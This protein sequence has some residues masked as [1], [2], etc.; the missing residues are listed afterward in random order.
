MKDVLSRWSLIVAIIAGWIVGGVSAQDIVFPAPVVRVDGV[1]DVANEAQRQIDA[2]VEVQSKILR[3]GLA[4]RIDE[5][6]RVCDLQPEQLKKF[7][8]AAKGVVERSMETWKKQFEQ[9]PQAFPQANAFFAAP[10]FAQE[11]PIADVEEAPAGAYRP[12]DADG[13]VEAVEDPSVEDQPVDEQPEECDGAEVQPA[14][15]DVA[16]PIAGPPIAAPPFAAPA[17]IPPP[18]IAMPAIQ[19]VPAQVI[20]AMPA[21]NWQFSGA[22]VPD[23]GDAEHHEIWVRALENI[24]TQEQQRL[25]QEARQRRFRFRQQVAIHAIV[26]ELDAALLFTQQQREEVLAMLEKRSDELLAAGGGVMHTTS[27]LH[28]LPDDV[29]QGI[30]SD[31]QLDCIKDFKER[32]NVIFDIPVEQPMQVIPALPAVQFE[33]VIDEEDADDDD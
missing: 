5:L 11:V 29:F 23:A 32:N 16:P 31:A 12:V 15:P 7:Q 14:V 2:I 9:V 6:E 25:Y 33:A 26:A 10:R 24:L 13:Y 20:R 28:Q 22:V 19:M 1:I 3:Q 27:L 8:V 30:L 4:V 18:Q 17:A 21:G